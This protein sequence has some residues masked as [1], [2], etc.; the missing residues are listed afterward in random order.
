MDVSRGGISPFPSFRGSLDRASR[1]SFRGSAT[2]RARRGR[3]QHARIR[4]D[5]RRIAPKRFTFSPAAESSLPLAGRDKQ[6]KPPACEGEAR[7][8]HGIR[9]DLRFLFHSLRCNKIMKFSVSCSASVRSSMTGTAR[10]V[11]SPPWR[12]AGFWSASRIRPVRVPASPHR[13]PDYR[14]SRFPSQ[15]GCPTDDF[16]PAGSHEAAASADSQVH[17]V[18]LSFAGS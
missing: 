5:A 9:N 3:T 17:E 15:T 11:K 2:G 1:H 4:Q 16:A 14:R 8:H 6:N 7:Q 18:R 10:Q 12:A 13:R